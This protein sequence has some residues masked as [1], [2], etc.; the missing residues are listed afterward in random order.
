MRLRSLLALILSLSTITA[1]ATTPANKT[2][3][4]LELGVTGDIEI[5]RD[6]SVR[7]YRVT[8][9]LAPAL[10]RVVEKHVRTW[11]FEPIEV[12]GR[13]MIAKTA[14]RLQ[15]RAEPTDDDYRLLVEHVSFGEARS[16][17]TTRP[18][19]PRDA[20]RAGVG[21]RVLLQVRIDALGNVVAAH[22]YQTS[23]AAA[24]LTDARA[25]KWREVFE[26]VSLDAV[27]SWKYAP[28]EVVDGQSAEQT[29][30]IPIA[31]E[32]SE[33]PRLRSSEGRWKAYTPG[34]ITP[35]PWIDADDAVGTD[36]DAIADG[37]TRSL[38][39]R[40]RLKNAIAG[41]VL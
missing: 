6:G 1:V 38:S 29:A 9:E 13:P 5:D 31:F 22:A 27:A 14:V 34:P 25:R 12:D 41:A 4:E 7:D 15:L 11:A 36:T 19:Y 20:V 28:S 18:R 2:E 30:M 24:G 40:F 37:E 3:P 17:Q 8:S 16:A 26:R 32:I 23:L 39:S 21:A 33:G 35:A 10:Q